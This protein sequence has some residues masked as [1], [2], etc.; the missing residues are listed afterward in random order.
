VTDIKKSIL[1]TVGRTPL[2]RINRVFSKP[3]VQILAKLEGFNPCGSVKERIAVAMLEGAEREGALRPG[4]T[5]V[6]SSSGNTGVGLAMAAAVKGYP[7]LI[8]MAKKASRERRQYIRAFGAKLVLVDGGS[9]EAWDEADRIAAS[10]PKKYFRIHQYRMKENVQVHYE[11]T[12]PE[13]WEQTGG[14]IDV[15]VGTLGTTGTVV[16]VSRFLRERNPRVRIVSVEPTPKNEQ[17]GIRNLRTQ[18]TPEI[19]DPASVDER[20]ICRDGPAFRLARLLASKEGIF[21]GISSGSALWGAIGQAK[22]LPKGTVVVV[23]PDSGAKYL[24]TRLF[25]D[26][27]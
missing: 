17:Q 2:V 23:F 5:L 24:S 14:K 9:D 21:A 1:E 25:E 22:R 18:R 4:R 27:E 15:F 3:G 12:G 13:I 11:S 10:N 19:W 20:M 7:C 8:T 6:E 26:V 16:G